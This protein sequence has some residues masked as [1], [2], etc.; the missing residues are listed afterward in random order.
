MPFVHGKR[1]R[2]WIDQYEMT[3]FFN[4]FTMAAKAG[5][6]ETTVYG[7]G[8]KTYIGGLKEGQ[9]SAK[10]F[11]GADTTDIQDPELS[12]A[13]GRN[14][15]MIITFS[16]SGLTVPGTPAV[17]SYAAEVD[18][19][20]TAPVT[21]VV[22]FTM[23]AQADSGLSSGVILNDPSVAE[24]GATPSTYNNS[25]LSGVSQGIND[26]NLG[27]GKTTTGGLVAVLHVLALAG[28]GS[29]SFTAVLQQSD[30]NSTWAALTDFNDSGGTA[31]PITAVGAYAAFVGFNV[32]INRYIQ[33][34]IVTAG[35]TVTALS[36]LV[37]VSRQ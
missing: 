16:E 36:A 2:L 1:A 35:T 3:G 12:A 24:T 28:T 25:V 6:A 11:Y 26:R 8:A 33:C 23:T 7:R 34:Q 31:Q 30:D 18:Y 14:Q 4:D 19:S 27:A 29:P 13:L 5:I 22:A 21:G 9:I 20:V 17:A 37:T 15:N 10:G 32:P